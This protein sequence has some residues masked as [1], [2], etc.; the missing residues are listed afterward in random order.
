MSLAPTRPETVDAASE[1]AAE[2]ATAEDATAE[3][4][5][6]TAEETA[7]E[8]SD[9]PG[10]R[11][12]SLRGPVL[13]ALCVAMLVAGGLLLV[14]ARGQADDARSVNRALYDASTTTEVEGQIG[15]GLARV[16]TFDHRRPEATR[17]AADE[18]MRGKAREQY[19]ELYAALVDLAPQQQLSTRV[20]VRATAVQELE[21]DRAEVLVF[22]DQTSTRGTDGES[23]VGAAQVQ[24][25][26]QRI[27]GAW[28]VL[29]LDLR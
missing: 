13:A 24:V 23:S 9:A 14:L 18:L 17:A 10:G 3:T 12:R 25:S 5:G 15:T 6:E 21:G 16:L 27:D 4:A 28:R 19:D 8:T 29:D 7:G 22:L 20:E 1:D 11:R 26:A 2:D